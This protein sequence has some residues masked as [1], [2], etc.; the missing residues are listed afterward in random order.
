MVAIL[1]SEVQFG[2][3]DIFK[4]THG[5]D[6]LN[7]CRQLAGNA[8]AL[9]VVMRRTS[10]LVIPP[11]LPSSGRHID[12]MEEFFT[13]ISL[14]TGGQFIHIK[15]VKL[16]SEVKRFLS[17]YCVDY[18][19]LHELQKKWIVVSCGQFALRPVQTPLHSCAERN[20]WIEYGKRAVSESIWCGK[21]VKCYRVCRTFVELIL[22]SKH[23]APSEWDVALVS[24]QSRYSIR[25]GTWKVRLLN[26]T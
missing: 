24:L 26:L 2:T 14:M 25:F 5:H 9:Y 6:V 17:I 8:V 20:W 11:Y 7:L 1:A 15:S 3:L 18:N 16:V 10:K 4:C 13:G 22:G 12:L 19:Q 21:S 23:G